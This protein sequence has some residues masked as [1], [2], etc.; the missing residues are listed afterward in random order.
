MQTFQVAAH[1]T[2]KIEI[3]EAGQYTV[4]LVG[5]GA[6]VDIHGVFLTKEKDDVNIELYIIHKAPHTSAQTT[7][8]GVAKDQS[9][10]RFFGRII[11]DPGCPG[12]QSFLEER[13]LLL[14]DKAHAEA[15]PELEILSDDV[16]CSHAATI[17]P[18]PEEHLFY[19][20]SR[21]INKETAEQLIVD[22]FLEQ[23]T[24]E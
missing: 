6:H 15:V 5:Q 3:T 10:I 8:K 23:V 16:K 9:H 11:I 4:E 21:G 18:I 14:S 22:G 19:L 12:T 1:Q 24:E 20:R 13:I 17:S 7:L 2:E